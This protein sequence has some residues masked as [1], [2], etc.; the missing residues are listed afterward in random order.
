[1]T[2]DA[3]F[4]DGGERPLY[5]GA[6]DPDDLQVI[7]ALVQDAV[8]PV[9]EMRWRA[10]ERRCSSCAAVTGAVITKSRRSKVHFAPA[11]TLVALVWDDSAPN[12]SDLQ[13]GEKNRL[14]PVGPIFAR[15]EKQS[16][17]ASHRPKR[18]PTS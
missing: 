7:S 2:E 1:M 8:L 6:L 10:G 5:L 3:R 17:S 13:C 15:G 14:Q 16:N 9:T 12:S 4:E 18:R 11:D